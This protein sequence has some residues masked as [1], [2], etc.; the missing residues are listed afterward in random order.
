MAQIAHNP[1]MQPDY[2]TTMELGAVL[3]LTAEVRDGHLW[4]GGV[5][6]V[7]LAR[8][9]GTALY[10][11][12]EEHIR[13][14][15]RQFL[16]W[17]RCHWKDVDIVYACKA[18][19]SKALCR[20]VHE[21]GCFLD[22][23]SGG[24]LAIALAAGFPPERIV[25]H[26]NN[27][28]FRELAEAIDAG[29]GRIVVDS[30]EE[31]ARIDHIAQERNLTQPILIRVTPGVVADTH[32]YMQTGAED[33]KFGFGLRDG[34]AME[35]I[36]KAISLPSIDFKGLHMH[37]GSQIFA[38][39]SYA[40]AIE[41]MV[42]FMDEIRT[43]TGFVISELNAGGGLGVA[44]GVLDAPSTIQQFGKVIV[45]DIKEHCDQHGLPVP[46]IMIEPGRAVVANAGVT[47]YTVGT[48]KHIPG[49]RTYVAVDGGMSD[50]IRKALYSAHYEPVIANRADK[51]R[52]TVVTIAGKHC[53]SGDVIIVDTPLQQAEIDDVLCVFATGA[54]CQSMASNYNKQVRPGVVFVRDGKARLV[55]RRETYDDLMLCE[56]E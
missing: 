24:E 50:N 10:V 1:D 16:E 36:Q 2:K 43:K 7:K 25:S 31:L 14:Q 39:N 30:L 37:I 5:D 34:L 26:G 6:T 51:P 40:K 28:T 44:Y 52:D 20:L 42:H 19:I 45:D 12:D 33:S 53:E 54:Y 41:V 9:M 8:E 48:I 35:A 4:I 15:L 11:M 55:V 21:E 46:R 18:F 32:E 3:P 27:K 56:V 47:L 23:S 49:V 38:L 22:V 29:V 13:T 17:T